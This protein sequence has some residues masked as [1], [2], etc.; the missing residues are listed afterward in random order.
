MSLRP[1]TDSLINAPC[2]LIYFTQQS[3]MANNIPVPYRLNT[4]SQNQQISNARFTCPIIPT[5][6]LLDR[7]ISTCPTYF[8]TC[9][10]CWRDFDK[11]C[12][13]VGAE[14]RIVCL[15][16]WKWMFA[17]S[18]CWNC[19]EVVFRKSDAISFGW[20]W[21]HWSCF[22]CLVCS[23]SNNFK[24]EPSTTNAIGTITSLYISQSI[25]QF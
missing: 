13:T 10:V 8:Y 14:S 11:P 5:R 17:V 19:G 21:W 1:S 22:S 6:S 25:R 4:K 24:T 16:C 3:N 9:S 23:V 20:C 15:D 7:R 18:I 2:H 12:Y